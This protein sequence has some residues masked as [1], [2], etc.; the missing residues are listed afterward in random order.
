M[1]GRNEWRGPRGRPRRRTPLSTAEQIAD[2]VGE[3]IVAGV[4]QPGV[5]ILELDLC[6][7][8][9]VSRAPVREAF[10]VLEQEGLV[11]VVPRQGARVTQLNLK[12]LHDIFTVREELVVFT[13]RCLGEK[14]DP[15]VPGV[16][17]EA[18]DN[19]ARLAKEADSA[20]PFLDESLGLLIRLAEMTDNSV[21]PRMIWGLGRQTMRYSRVALAERDRR[22]ESA[23]LWNELAKAYDTGDREVIEAAARRMA[24]AARQRA[25][26][27][28]QTI[29]PPSS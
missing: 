4:Y 21:L 20:A 29:D 19:M 9:G 28:V 18:I 23:R 26:A 17:R 3:D 25:I 24:Q 7:A 6:G 13:M 1:L 11:Q 27:G 12:E 22:R 2:A 16:M 15:E 5:R 14:G 10:R 8:F